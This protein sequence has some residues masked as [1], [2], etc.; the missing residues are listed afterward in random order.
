MGIF[1]K[2]FNSKNNETKKQKE[3]K[4]K[5]ELSIEKE[6]VKKDVY[7]PKLG[8]ANRY[9]NALNLNPSLAEE[10]DKEAV[11]LAKK[12]LEVVKIIR[13]NPESASLHSENSGNRWNIHYLDDISD[14][15]K[16]LYGLYDIKRI[17]SLA[18]GDVSVFLEEYEFLKDYKLK[19]HKV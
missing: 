17:R 19:K 2:F 14:K 7:E 13:D 10:I 11:F 3:A 18:P 9:E 4:K 1:E 5:Q 8:E 6:P 16:D 12:A 15:M